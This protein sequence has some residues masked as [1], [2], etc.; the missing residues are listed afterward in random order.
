M[1]RA[2]EL[3]WEA[4]RSGCLPVGAVIVDGNGTVVAEGRNRMADT[5]APPGRLRNTAIAHAEVDALSQLP[6]GTYPDH[7]LFTSLEPC[8][9]CRSAT[10]MSRVGTIEFLGRDAVCEGLDRLPELNEHAAARHPVLR[11][12]GDG[13]EARFASILPL[14]VLCG[15]NEQGHSMTVHRR[16]APDHALAAERI[17]AE[18]LW[19]SPALGVN[20][21]IEHLRPVLEDRGRASA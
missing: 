1:R 2:L 4:Y 18:G 12:P 9:L 3:A 6:F 13:I 16:H 5:D 19:P 17:V 7:V 14:A 20:E 10:V 15:I 8:L 11:G 21:A